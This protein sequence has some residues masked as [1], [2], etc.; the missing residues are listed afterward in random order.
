MH[1]IMVDPDP[2]ATAA[3]LDTRLKQFSEEQVGPR[4]TLHF[5]LSVRD[6]NGGL[7][8]GLIGE[9]LWNALL[10]SVLW[11]HAQ[12][13]QS[14]YGTALMARAEQLA[15]ER[16]CEV[17]F[18]NTMTFQ[19]P[20]FYSKLGYTVFGQ[21]PDAPRGHSRVWFCKRLSGAGTL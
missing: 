17:A 1:P 7:V 10:I 5:V 3:E 6:G 16:K 12:H 8:G 20:G 21:L 2:A 18:L 15:R 4:N 14:G 19:A 11:V 9:T 13:R